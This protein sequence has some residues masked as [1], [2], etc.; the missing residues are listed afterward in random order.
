MTGYKLSPLPWSHVPA[1]PGHKAH[2]GLHFC[3]PHCCSHGCR[4]CSPQGNDR[5]QTTGTLLHMCLSDGYHRHPPKIA[6]N[7]D[8]R[9]A[10][11][12]TVRAV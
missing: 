1:S 4:V 12:V 9:T 10:R 5:L 3:L 7:Y 2:G 6:M 8:D 11:F